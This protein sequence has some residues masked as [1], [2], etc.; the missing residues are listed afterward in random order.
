MVGASA[1]AADPTSTT[2]IPTVEGSGT[3]IP[4]LKSASS[5]DCEAQPGRSINLNG[6]DLRGRDFSD[7]DL[8]YA[9]FM[10]ANLEGAHFS[11]AKLIHTNFTNSQLSTTTFDNSIFNSS[12]FTG[13]TVDLANVVGGS[14]DGLSVGLPTWS[15][16]P[17]LSVTVNG[18]QLDLSNLIKGTRD[19]KVMTLGDKCTIPLDGDGF[20]RTPTHVTNCP[21]GLQWGIDAIFGS[22]SPIDLVP[23]MN[24]TEGTVTA[25]KTIEVRD[26]FGR[27][28]SCSLT[29][30]MTYQT[31][32]VQLGDLE[33]LVNE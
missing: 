32:Y 16:P 23:L 20:R 22:G 13:T 33:Y 1:F 28:R 17:S 8:T 5:P 15:I 26:S 31:S 11:N 4:P 18:P 27:I 6:C 9:S 25:I 24:L 2:A 10:G 14:G 21:S 19:M 12:T 3:T 29:I 7:I 30:T